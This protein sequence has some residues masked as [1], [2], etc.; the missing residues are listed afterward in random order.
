MASTLTVDTIVGATSASTVHVPGHVIQTVHIEGGDDVSFSTGAS[1]TSGSLVGNITPK[2]ATSKILVVGQ[3]PLRH[4]GTDDIL[5]GAIRL[6]REVSGTA[7]TVWNEHNGTEQFQVRGGPG[8]ISFVIPFSVLDSPATTSSIEYK[9][10]GY[11]LTG[12]GPM[13]LWRGARGS[14]FTL[15]EI[16]Q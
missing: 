4:Q 14:R 12:G 10:Q 11:I 2:F 15:M 7:T 3:Q 13:I 1:W 8:E 5:R 16:A 6:R 9:I